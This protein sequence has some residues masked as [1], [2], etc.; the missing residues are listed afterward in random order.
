MSLNH[1]AKLQIDIDPLFLPLP[2]EQEEQASESEEGEEEKEEDAKVQLP[3]PPSFSDELLDRYAK[4]YQQQHLHSQNEN[5]PPTSCSSS[6]RSRS[7][8]RSQQPPSKPVRVLNL[9]RQKCEEISADSTVHFGGKR[10]SGKSFAMRNILIWKN[11]PRVVVIGKGRDWKTWE[12][13]VGM[14]YIYMEFREEIFYGFL[15]SQEQLLKLQ[16]TPEGKSLNIDLTIVLEDF[17]SD[18]KVMRSQAIADLVANGRRLHILFLC[19]AQYLKSLRPE[20][21]TQFDYYFLF[22]EKNQDV[23]K[24]LYEAVGSYYDS[25]SEFYKLLDTTTKEKRCLIVNTTTDKNDRV[26]DFSRHFKARA[27]KARPLGS[28]LYRVFHTLYYKPQSNQPDRD[29]S[30]MLEVQAAPEIQKSKVILNMNQ[31]DIIPTKELEAQASKEGVSEV[32]VSSSKT[33]THIISFQD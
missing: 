30:A 31:H 10:R 19:S 12:G 14:S 25:K 33:E 6:S 27:Y 5:L 17:S 21:R 26:E 20:V 22:Q 11:T 8:S 2:E 3:T 9:P 24:H 29:F 7:R 1:V 23:R 32:V 4:M 15:Q 16:E 13:S 28:F 18:K